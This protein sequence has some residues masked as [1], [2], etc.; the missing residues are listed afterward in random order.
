MRGPALDGVAGTPMCGIF[1]LLQATPFD[2]G[3]LAEVSRRLAHRGPDGEGFLVCTA[4]G[5]VPLAGPDTPATVLASR[6]AFAPRARV[7]DAAL[8]AGGVV[9]GHRRLAILDVSPMG[10]QP[11]AAPG[12]R[13]WLTYNG[14][15]YNFVELREELARLGHA[16]VG[17]SDS[18]VI[19]AAYAEWGPA[20]QDRFVGMWAFAVLDIE[21]R[22]LFLS[23]D[24]FGIKPLY[25]YAAGGRLAFASE[26]KAFGA[27][28]GWRARANKHRLGDFLVW[29]LSDHAVETMFAGVTQLMPGHCAQVDVGALFVGQPAPS[30]VDA[31]RWYEPT[32]ANPLDRDGGA[33]ALR[34]TLDDAVR[35]HLRSDVPVGSCLS[36]GLDSSA[37]VCLMARALAAAG[38]GSPRTFTAR[39]RDAGFDESMYAAAV[40]RATGASPHT[41]TPDPGRLFEVLDRIVW[42][43]DEPFLGTSIFA[44]W[45]VFERARE[46]GVP[47]VLDG[48]GADEILGGYRG[49]YGAYLAGLARA[50][51]VGAWAREVR[52]L[53]REIGFSPLRSAGYTAAYLTPRLVAAVGRIDRRAYSDRG[54]LR[55]AERGAF[56]TDPFL[57]AGGRAA[58]VRE[59][60]LAQITAT[61]LPMLLH[62]EDR[63]S[64]AF[65]VEAR[66]PFLDHRVVEL[67]LALSDAD[68]VG[69]GVSKGVLR[70]AMRGIVPDL[71]LDRRDKMGF[72]TAEPLWVRRDDPAGFRRELRAAL[73]SLPEILDP[74]LLARFDEVVAG[75]RPFDQRYWRAISAGRWAVRFAVGA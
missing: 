16:F 3:E 11:M 13:H 23:R 60:S 67:C 64:M 24:R 49:F 68:K 39:S 40:V 71:V 51:R 36:G 18:E 20:C 44:Q 22:T 62:W 75:R 1:G 31:V 19:L 43:Q 47:V 9:L 46:A 54:W 50:G 45:L 33:E 34:A 37:I 65:S 74:S 32:P 41:V 7:G 48:Q 52:H 21:A 61:N 4:D 38:G 28:R 55:P 10:H 17:H 30:R 63:N 56:R 53:R 72:V 69:G 70:R 29:N 66:V 25:L 27:L 42:H 2:A 35:L 5:A 6:T 73:D 8:R 26:I 57:A 15:I 58:S 14:E 59:M 12:G